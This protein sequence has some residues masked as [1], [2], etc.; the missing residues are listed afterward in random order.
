MDA[1]IP[2]PVG[3]HIRKPSVLPWNERQS[4]RGTLRGKTVLTQGELDNRGRL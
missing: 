2:H 4:P 3:G 1:R